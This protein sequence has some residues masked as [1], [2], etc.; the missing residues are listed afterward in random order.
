[1]SQIQKD[2]E[3]ENENIK[4]DRD[5]EKKVTGRQTDKKKGSNERKWRREGNGSSLIS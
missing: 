5:I 2:S 4:I 1:M 3:V